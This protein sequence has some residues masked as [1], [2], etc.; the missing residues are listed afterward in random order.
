[1]RPS[2]FLHFGCEDFFLPNVANPCI[3]AAEVT[4]LA[5]VASFLSCS[6]EP[7]APNC[8]CVGYCLKATFRSSGS[9]CLPSAVKHPLLER[10]VLSNAKNTWSASIKDCF[11]LSLLSALSSVY[12][13]FSGSG[14]LLY[15]LS[16]S[17]NCAA[18]A[19]RGGKEAFPGPSVLSFL[20]PG[21]CRCGE[22]EGSYV[23]AARGWLSL[24]QL[25]LTTFLLSFSI[26][27]RNGG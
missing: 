3:M 9:C 15:L 10:R 5:T 7:R 16:S 19:G 21:S 14:S 25:L 8:G 23:W 27:P 17:L 2:P 24:W 20:L 18:R 13:V 6:F 12:N 4:M 22:R 26:Q 1:M 11:Q